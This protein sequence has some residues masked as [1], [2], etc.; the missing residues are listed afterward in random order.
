MKYS[1]RLRGGVSMKCRTRASA[2]PCIT[3]RT[4]L[5][6]G[7]LRNRKA[8]LPLSNLAPQSPARLD[9]KQQVL[10]AQPLL[11][12]AINSDEVAGRVA[13]L[14]TL[15]QLLGRREDG[16]GHRFTPVRSDG[17]RPDPRP[18]VWSYN[19]SRGGSSRG[20]SLRESSSFHSRLASSVRRP[21]VDLAGQKL[22]VLAERRRRL[23]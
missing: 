21:R 7:F 22:R 1:D 14:L 17:L 12:F 6:S 5:A 15:D 13:P 18:G 23:G 2:R 19:G 16:R 3:T 8:L 20:G 10:V 9:T 4:T 11:P